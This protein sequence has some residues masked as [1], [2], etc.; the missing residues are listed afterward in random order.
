MTL[1]EFK[2]RFGWPG[3]LVDG[4]GWVTETERRCLIALA[5]YIRAKT[6]VEI[7]VQEGRTARAIL[8]ALPDPVAYFG[9]DIAPGYPVPASQLPEV[10]TYPGWRV[11]DPR[12]FLCLDDEGWRN[13]SLPVMQPDM[14]FID[15]DHTESAVADHTDRAIEAGSR[16]IVWHDVG[17]RMQPGVDEALHIIHG[18]RG[19]PV[20]RIN[21]TGLALAFTG[22]SRQ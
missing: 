11:S 5:K 1:A 19:I 7:G 8:A 15:A 17:N 20:T 6:I 10:P 18:A 9:L 16:L 14:V 12:F 4:E 2:R 3:G 22:G 21:G 13:R